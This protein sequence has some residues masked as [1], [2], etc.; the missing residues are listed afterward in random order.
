MYN[1]KGL[2]VN[3]INVKYQMSISYHSEDISTV[4]ACQSEKMVSYERRWMVNNL[5]I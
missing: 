2:S 5:N 1:F 4:S 3:K